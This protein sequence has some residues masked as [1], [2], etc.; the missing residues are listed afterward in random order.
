MNFQTELN[1]VIDGLNAAELTSHKAKGYKHEP[2][3]W[4]YEERKKYIAIDCGTSGAFLMDKETGE[5]Y[6]IKG[7]GV[8]NHNKKKKADIGNITN[9]DSA[10][11]HSKRWNYLR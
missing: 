10:V 1:R 11:L 9:V 8:P 5:L 7:Y 2:D 4:H 3:R 6:N